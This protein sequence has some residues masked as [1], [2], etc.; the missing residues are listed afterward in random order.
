MKTRLAFVLTLIVFSA[1]AQDFGNKAKYRQA[2][3]ELSAQP[4][5][6]NRI[7]LFGDSITEFWSKE[8]P[9]FFEG[10]PYLINRGIGGQTTPQ[11][12]DR[13]DDDVIALQPNTVVILAGT[14]DIA[15]N[16][17]KTTLEQ[18][19][20]NLVKMVESAKR[21]HIRPVLCALLPA[22]AYGWNPSV[23]PGPEIVKLNAM[24]R[25]YAK[26]EKIAFV[27][28]HSVLDDGHLGL[29]K[30]YSKDGVHPNRSGYR[31]MEEQL[32]RALAR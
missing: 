24:L 17:G 25:D 8:D 2:N 23:Q 31:V 6:G 10:K 12:L 9:S 1:Y 15:G 22:A 26:R 18:I 7:V 28:Y 4:N 29:S 27:D 3:A 32:A 30:K 16:T 13:F 11:L 5:P 20:R 21:H 19:Y 14:N